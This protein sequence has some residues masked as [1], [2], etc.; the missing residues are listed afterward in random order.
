MGLRHGDPSL[1]YRWSRE[2]QIAAYA[3]GRI[4]SDPAQESPAAPAAAPVAA[5]S[6]FLSLPQVNATSPEAQRFWSNP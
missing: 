6:G 4:R 5:S 3:I 2:D 1:V